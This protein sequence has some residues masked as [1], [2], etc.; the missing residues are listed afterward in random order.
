[1]GA[2][3]SA[4]RFQTFN[5]RTG[6]LRTSVELACVSIRDEPP[7]LAGRAILP[8]PLSGRQLPS[9]CWVPRLTGEGLTTVSPGGEACS[10]DMPI[11]RLNRPLVYLGTGVVARLK[12]AGEQQVNLKVVPTRT[13]AEESVDAAH[14]QFHRRMRRTPERPK[15]EWGDK[16]GIAK[17]PV[18][19]WRQIRVIPA[20]FQAALTLSR[21]IGSVG[22]RARTGLRLLIDTG[23][24]TLYSGYLR[25]PGKV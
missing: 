12:L 10:T 14:E 3:S 23:V 24:V 5:C 9:N 22:D 8:T 16:T 1:M 19:A 7:L 15:G 4:D 13:A 17:M 2:P 6:A 21:P 11:C 18:K 25:V 20:T